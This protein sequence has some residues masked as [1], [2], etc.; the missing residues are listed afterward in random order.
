MQ[1][2][3]THC[4]HTADGACA[5]CN[6]AQPTLLTYYGMKSVGLPITT[7]EEWERQMAADR[8]VE[9]SKQLVSEVD[10]SLREL[11][12]FALASAVRLHQATGGAL[13]SELV[14]GSVVTA[15]AERFMTFLLEGKP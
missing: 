4:P 13:A 12:K 10:P 3:L 1:V 14:K 7:L 8:N 11:R 6:R 5:R 2:T 15:D 9:Q